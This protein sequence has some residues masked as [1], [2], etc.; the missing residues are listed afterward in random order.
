MPM[1]EFL[2]DY[3]GGV[4]KKKKSLIV[5]DDINEPRQLDHFLRIENIH[6]ES[7]IIIT[8]RK[9]NTHNWFK[10][11]TWRYHEYKMELLDFDESL[12]LL[13]LHAFG[14]KIPKE[15]YKELTKEVLHYCGGNPLALEVLGSSLRED[16]SIPFWRNTLDLLK[17][18]INYDIQHVLIRSFDSLPNKNSK[19]LFLHIVFFFVG[20]DKDYVEQILE[21]DY[22]ASYGIQVLIN[23]CLLSV[24]PNNK[25]MMHQ[26]IQ[27]MGK[28][29]VHEE[30]KL[31]I[32]R[33]RV[34]SS[35]SCKILR[36]GEGSK[37]M[38]GL[39]LDMQLLEEPF[40]RN[41]R[42]NLKVNPNNAPDFKTDSLTKMDNLK[43]LKLNDVHL[44]GSYEDFSEDLRWLHWRRC[45]LITI[46]S[47]L[48][49]RNLVT[50]DMRDSMLEVFEPPIVLPFLKTLDLRGSMSLSEI[51]YI[52]R[53]PNLET[54]IL[55]HCS[56]LVLAFESIGRLT[57]LSL[58][59]MIGCDKFWR[60][61]GSANKR[62]RASTSGGGGPQQ[63]SLPLP[64]SL[65]WLSLRDCNFEITEYFILRFD[66]Q[67]KLQYLDLGGGWFYSLPSYNHLENLRVLDLSSC[68]NLKQLLCLPRALAELY[69]YY[70]T[71]LE[72]IT[73]E[74]HQFTLQG[75]GY[76]GCSQ[77]I[78]IEGFFKLV[79]IAELDETDLG[80]MVWLK[81]YQHHE[82][83]LIGGDIQFTYNRSQNI[84]M[85]YEFGI[86]STSL[87]DIKDPNMIYE[88]SSE[89]PS[90]C[91][92]V[93]SRPE[94]KRLIGLNI[95]F[96]YTI[97][98]DDDPAWFV[99]IHTSNGVD[100]MYN[101]HVFGHPGEGEVGMWLSFWP[102]GTKLVTGEEV[103]VSIVVM[104]EIMEAKE[105]GASLVYAEDDETM[106]INMPWAETI[107]G[108]LSAFQLSTGANYL[109]RRDFFKLMEVGRLTPGWLSILVG[110]TIDDR[111]VRGWRK[112]GR[113]NTSFN[114]SG[115]ESLRPSLAELLDSSF[116]LSRTRSSRPSLI[117]LQDSSLTEF[118][119][120]SSTESKN[121]KRG[122]GGEV[123]P[124]AL[125][126]MARTWGSGGSL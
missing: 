125:D 22:C 12:E 44:A 65:V 11:R 37:T 111:E 126:A 89:S 55:C 46:P 96:K 124:Q 41:V 48:L 92:R 74:S 102:I 47:G 100:Y 94:N 9:T 40:F 112:T 121:V 86:M 122:R 5:F 20:E 108:D 8:T 99:K 95:S 50:L 32:E 82:I 38:E 54:L 56:E 25:L 78:E 123:K 16:V 113:P 104:S 114:L 63:T 71:S 72:R 7:K 115:T 6:E 76:K 14:F 28:S 93:P 24:S 75:F 49:Q 36:K 43:L 69:V 30:S 117:E 91:F 118:P 77:L 64:D 110:H 87:P 62:R 107:R 13:S 70:C 4:L 83:C 2:G 119:G 80:H 15:G 21:H 66:I 17:R 57:N 98:D 35:D 97:S 81:E 45:S 67:R 116:N 26:L 85:L 120:S 10:P 61:I 105:C 109:C 90:V 53:L 34:L 33:S 103:N 88:Y 31:P 59:N 58:L 39:A 68:Y 23:R 1:P 106:E 101:P 29:I 51:H 27:E 73:F 79:E 3:I 18:E 60:N 84:Q 42:Q 52:S 19:E